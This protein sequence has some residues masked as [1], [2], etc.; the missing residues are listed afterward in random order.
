MSETRIIVIGAGMGGLSA[1]IALAAKGCDVTIL[2]RG[3]A[4][5]GKARTQDSAAGP[6]NAG[7]TV[8]TLRVVFDEL[9][10]EA[11]AALDD[12]VTLAPEPLLARHFWP[13]GSRLDLTSNEGEN[14]RAIANFA[15]PAA[16]KEFRAF[17]AR[18]RRLFAT[19]EDPMLRAPAPRPLSFAALVARDP[20]LLRAMSPGRSLAGRLARDFTDPRLRQLFGRY[21]TYVGGSPF[22]TP[23]LLSLIWEAEA[24]GIWRVEGGIAALARGMA[25]LATD[26]GARIRYAS[27]ATRIVTDEGRVSAVELEDGTVLDCDRVVFN[28]DPR[29]LRHGLLGSDVTDAVP[30]GAVEPLSL[31]AEVWAFAARPQGADLVH[32]NV[33]FGRDPHSEFDRIA[34]GLP[35]LDPTIY[36]CAQDRGTGRT[37]PDG[38][39]RFEIIVNAAPD[40]P[41]QEFNQCR[42]RTF[43]TLAERD[44]RFDP[45]PPATALTGPRG[46]GRLFPGSGGALYGRS[47]QG[48]MAAFRRPTAQSA[49]PGLYLAGGGTHPGA[50]V[51]M[52]ALSGRHAASAIGLSLS[53]TGRSD[54]ADMHGGI[55]TESPTTEPAASRPSGS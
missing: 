37:P 27:V 46:F 52:A 25:A 16:G 22:G 9:F 51:P 24:A 50:G 12:Y 39:E 21:A 26:L 6:V 41:E 35:P 48:T 49:V 36:V 2:D 17:A 38:P 42:Q 19:F 1:A 33:F 14:A 5:G 15:G 7:P 34:D 47:P 20:G 45:E 23:A 4:P 40:T 32:H 43:T 18:A 11:G 8:L 3:T 54:A 53:S 30:R 29:A 10:E 31:S 13:D 55:S 44:L 28:G